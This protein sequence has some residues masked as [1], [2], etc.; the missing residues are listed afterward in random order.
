VI[1]DKRFKSRYLVN[2]FTE[3]IQA[4]KDWLVN[5]PGRLE[6]LDK[7]LWSCGC[8][9]CTQTSDKEK[10]RRIGASNYSQHRASP[11]AALLA[12]LEGVGKSWESVRVLAN[13]PYNGIEALVKGH[14]SQRFSKLMDKSEETRIIRGY[15]KTNLYP[16]R[17][18][19]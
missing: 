9:A 14:A 13:R 3:P 18:R 10:P 2:R 19:N 6:D 17:T 7:T 11:Q 5:I 8:T 15:G 16:Q 1:R 4:Q 12:R